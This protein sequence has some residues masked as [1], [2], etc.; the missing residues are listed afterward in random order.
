M[1]PGGFVRL[2]NDLADRLLGFLFLVTGDDEARTAARGPHG[3]WSRTS[4]SCSMSPAK[5]LP[6]EKCQSAQRRPLKRAAVE[7]PPRVYAPVWASP[8]SRG[9]ARRRA[10]SRR[11]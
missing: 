11:R 2:R 5:S 7:L 10:N 4:T 3:A 9:C 6:L 8:R 1:G